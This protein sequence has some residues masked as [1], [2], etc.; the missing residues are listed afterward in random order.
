MTKNRFTDIVRYLRFDD[1]VNRAARQKTDELAPFRDIWTMFREQLHK[2][3]I[4]GSD[5]CVDEQLVAL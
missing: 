4:P 3:Y 5:L 1:K 2:Y